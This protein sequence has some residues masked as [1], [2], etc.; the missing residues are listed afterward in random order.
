MQELYKPQNVIQG[1]KGAKGLVVVVEIAIDKQTEVVEVCLRPLIAGYLWLYQPD[2]P[3]QASIVPFIPE[4]KN[5]MMKLCSST[6][7]TPGV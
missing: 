3:S 5:L 6:L 1:S 2:I 7:A 4:L